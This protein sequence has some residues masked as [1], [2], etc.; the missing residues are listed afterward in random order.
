MT[1]TP[2]QHAKPVRPPQCRRSKSGAA[3]IALLLVLPAAG[4]GLLARTAIPAAPLAGAKEDGARAARDYLPSGRIVSRFG[5]LQEVLAHPD[6]IPTHAH[7]LLGSQ[8]PD[9]ELTDP[10]GRVW[11]LRE[12]RDGRPVVLIFYYGYQCISCVRQLCEIDRDLP[13]FREVGARVV[14][15]SADPAELTRR[16][17]QQFGPF[18]FLVLSDPGNK[19]AQ[20]YRVFEPA[21]DGKTAGIRRHGTFLIDRDGTVQWVNSGDAP[22]RRNPALLYELAKMEG[23][24]PPE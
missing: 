6:V 17:F 3:C 11:N 5:S 18:G 21:Q 2:R 16:R 4:L 13:L 12:L 7:P 20:A 24:L 22:L 9:F 14:A 8:A 15:I 1:E 19:V 10:E 23:R